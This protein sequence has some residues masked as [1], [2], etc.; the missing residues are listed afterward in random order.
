VADFKIQS[1]ANEPDYFSN[2]SYAGLINT[3]SGKLY[4]VVTGPQPL[5]I[6]GFLMVQVN[7]PANSNKVMRI[8]RVSGG[9]VN[10]TKIDIL[11]NATFPD[12]GTPLIPRNRNW[13]FA[14]QSVMIAKFLVG[15][16]KTVGGTLMSSR[17]QTG[18]PIEIN[19]DGE[20]YVP[21]ITSASQFYVRIQNNS[22]SPMRL[23]VNITW[24][25]L[26]LS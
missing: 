23:S 3:N 10:N 9:S 25:E 5:D 1:T 26:S 19:Y 13:G 16:D 7:N 8:Q 15:E 4:T 14:D 2:I 18:G 21:Y 6:S 17:I 11:K 24:S 22:T 20:F 12:A